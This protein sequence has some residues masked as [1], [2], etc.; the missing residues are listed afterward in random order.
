[1]GGQR[2]VLAP[3]FFL[4]YSPSTHL[5]PFLYLKLPHGP[6][7]LNLFQT[8]TKHHKSL[9]EVTI[10][11]T[12]TMVMGSKPLHRPQEGKEEFWF[13]GNL[14]IGSGAIFAPSPNSTHRV[15]AAC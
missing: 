6:N 12:T 4:H 15:A 8:Y 9:A 3:H 7:C 10:E 13:W 11:C 5:L 14:W 2:T 1:M